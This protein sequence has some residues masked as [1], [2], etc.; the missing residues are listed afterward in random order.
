MCN[1]RN[2]GHCPLSCP[3]FKTFEVSETVLRPDTSTYLYLLGPTE[4]VPPEDG[5]RIQFPKRR[6]LNKRQDDG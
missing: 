3:L 1:Y 2:S 4:Y 5:D 6:V